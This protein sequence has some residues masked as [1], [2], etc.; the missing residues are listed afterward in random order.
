[1]RDKPKRAITLSTTN[2]LY[3]FRIAMMSV[4]L[5]MAFLHPACAQ[6]QKVYAGLAEYSKWSFVAG[7]V[8]YNKAGITPQYGNLTFENRN[9]PGFNAGVMYDFNPDRKWSF[10]TGLL[11]AKEPIYSIRYKIE[12][13]DLFES[14]QGDLIDSYHSY[15]IYTFSFPLLLRLNVQTGDH[16]Y[17]SFL[18][19]LKAMYFPSGQQELTW[20]ISSD[21]LADYREI[22]GLKLESPENTMQGSFVIGTGYSLA[23]KKVLLK[24]TLL[25][26]MNFQNTITGE[27]QFANLFTSPDTR[28]YY[29][30]SGN[31]LGLLFAISFKKKSDER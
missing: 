28:G 21:E 1:M 25:Y 2:C 19:G 14:Y 17:A 20:A 26:V 9:M 27:Y 6:E 24:A 7:P 29:N 13:H 11:V 23:R 18:T 5:I 22:Y 4:V 16:S 15:A 3:G 30:L 8:L 10:Q 12:H 31:Y